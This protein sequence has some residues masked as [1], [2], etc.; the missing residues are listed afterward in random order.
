DIKSRFWATYK[1]EAEDCYSA[2]LDK[3]KDGMDII[4]IFSGLF[5]GVSTI[6]ITFM[7]LILHRQH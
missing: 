4:L 3:Y 6:F 5:S 1:R 7:Q 2:F